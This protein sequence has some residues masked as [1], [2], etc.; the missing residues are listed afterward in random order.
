MNVRQ[1]LA[2]LILLSAASAGSAAPTDAAASNLRIAVVQ[3]FV[4]PALAENQ[5][6]IVAG[7]ALAAGQRARVAVFPEGALSGSGE[8]R[9][10]AVEEAL[11]AIRRAASQRGIY[12]VMG[13]HTFLD[14]LKKA[15]NWML[16]V[17]PDGRE[18]FRYEKLYENHRAKMPGVFQI[19]GVPCGSMICADRWLRGV[20]EIPIQEGAQIG[21]ELSNNFACEWVPE[22]G[23]YWN[24][25]LAMRNAVW[26]VLAN[27]ANSAVAAE[28][29]KHGHS[30]VIAPD[31]RIVAAASGDTEELIV[32]D[33]EP[34]QATR[35]EALARAAHPALRAFWDA[36]IKLQQ[37][38]SIESPSFKAIKSAQAEIT[39]AAAGV[40]DD[41]PRMEGLIREAH[42]K[43][44]DLIAFP[45]QA[46]AE[47]ALE[48]LQAAARSNRIIVV[49]G[50]EHREAAGLRN[51]A[52]VIGPDGTVLTRYDQLSSSK[53]FQPGTNA[54]AMWFRVNGA[55][56][57]VTIGRDG[58]WSELS[59]LSAVAGA[60]VHIHLDCDSDSSPTARQRRLQVW[61]NAAS[62]RTFTATANVD[63]AMIWDD[64]HG[65]EE[66]RAVVKG[67]PRPDPGEVAVYSPFSANL[68]ARASP[69]GLVVVTRRVPAVNPYHPAKTSSLNPQMKAWYELGAQSISPR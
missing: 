35:A 37:G 57:F 48:K 46:I 36:G 54:A 6:R 29:S 2:A 24:V 65:D 28:K 44:A 69:G 41:L 55:A 39:L 18:V 5:D 31:G 9:P 3:M 7:I 25:P 16:V 32:A 53:P 64:L 38:Q 50:A 58:L 49:F 8:D 14:S 1:I 11:G 59:E 67:T 26:S 62:F 34:A 60:R 19:D 66:S 20:V 61:A 63:E 27:S 21:F 56:A 22:Y 42:A 68:V 17:G 40:V 12:V 15:G 45:A 33:V 43:K 52:F 30:A 47:E 13:A 4:R 23:R 51:S 10:E